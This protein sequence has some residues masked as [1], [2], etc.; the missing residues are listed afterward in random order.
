M[1]KYP[2]PGTA[3]LALQI[4]PPS[5]S[6]FFIAIVTDGTHTARL[7]VWEQGDEYWEPFSAEVDDRTIPD[8]IPDA[9]LAEL[10]AI[11]LAAA[12]AARSGS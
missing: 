9:Q 2:M 1:A 10:D 12:R 3:V 5:F 7:G 6:T 11:V 4:A 8:W